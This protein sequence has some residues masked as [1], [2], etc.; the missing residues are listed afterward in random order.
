[1][2]D[3]KMTDGE[4]CARLRMFSK[5]ILTVLRCQKSLKSILIEDTGEKTIKIFNKF[6]NTVLNSF[7]SQKVYFQKSYVTITNKISRIK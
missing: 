6:R 2:P 5:K 1:M 7:N 3:S 4:A